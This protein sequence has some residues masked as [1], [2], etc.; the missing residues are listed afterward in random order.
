MSPKA[1]TNS[2]RPPRPSSPRTRPMTQRLATQE[3]AY[4]AA[5]ESF[6]QNGAARDPAWARELR[7]A[8][9]SRFK[10]LGFPTARRGN[11]EWKYTDVGPVA[12]VPVQ[13]TGSTTALSLDP[14]DVQ[15]AA[16]GETGWPLLVFVNGR[17]DGVLSSLSSLPDG[18]TATNLAEAMQ[19]A[20]E[21]VQ[22]HLARY[23]DYEDNAFTALNTAFVPRGRVCARPKG[24]RG[25]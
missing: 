11:E 9:L 13:A 6:E 18:V 8:A 25:R 14:A 1:T 20:P 21:V 22:Q 24:S 16:F 5:S 7:K 10:A 4:L 2:R 15:E 19:L 3:E 12:R 17:Y 23:A